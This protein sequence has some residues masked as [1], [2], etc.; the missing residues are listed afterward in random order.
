MKIFL[1]LIVFGLLGCEVHAQSQTSRL[2]NAA[3]TI[4]RNISA[5]SFTWPQAAIT[6][7]TFSVEANN[8]HLNFQLAES[9]THPFSDALGKGQEARQVW[10]VNGLRYEREVR[11]YDNSSVITLS[12]RFI[13]ESTSDIRLGTTQLLQLGENGTWHLGIP[14]SGMTEAPAAVLN[15]GKLAQTA[16]LPFA[17]TLSERDYTSVGV[18][19]FASRVPRAALL[20]GYIRADEASPDI[21][22]NYVR[23]AGGVKLALTSRF[24]NRVIAPKQ[25]V[26]LNRVYL[27][28][29]EDVYALL[30]AY[31]DAMA[32]SAALP[33]R[34]GPVGLW[35][36]WYAHRMEVS[37]ENVL[38]NAAV[39]AQHFAPLGFEYMQVDHGWQRGDITG[40]WVPNERFPHG[41]KWLSDELKNKYGLKL[42]L[43]ISPTDV[44][45]SSQFYQQHP[46]WMLNGE[47]GK[48][49]VHWRWFW[50]PN[51]NCYQLDM[52]RQDAFDYTAATFKRLADEGVSYFKIDFIGGQNKEIFYPS[53]NQLTRGWPELRR[54]MQ[55][56]RAGAGDAWVRY[57]QG[58]PLLAAGLGDGSYGGDDTADAGQPGMFRVLRDNARILATSYWVSERVHTREV[59]DMSIRMHADIEE[60]RVRAALMTLANASI[61]WSDELQ[62][63]PPSRIRMMQQCMPPGN[64]PMRPVDLLERE[65]PSIWHIR[66]KNAAD[67][68]DVVGLFNF[69]E[70]HSEPRRVRLAELGL[71]EKAEYAVFEFWEEKFI[72]IVKGEVELMLPPATSRILSL[73]R[74][75]GKPQLIGTDM[76]VLQG[77][78]ELNQI[79]WDE[80]Q[81]ALSGTFTRM[82]GLSSKAFYYVPPTYAPKFEFP[83]SPRSARLTHVSGNVWM[84]EIEFKQKDFAWTIPFDQIKAATVKT[85]PPCQ[86]SFLSVI[87]NQKL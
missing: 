83:L 58:P 87:G 8:A 50:K 10:R 44:A 23:G 75:T 49:K 86:S 68:W 56:V 4:E 77:F 5:L 17:G 25:T 70:D 31:G 65:V 36:S 1:C 43:W 6:N 28:A 22:A 12:G 39:A 59:C 34:T 11:L 16:A 14:T 20:I 2:T 19:A 78:H 79:A 26:E 24:M 7:A 27:S 9:R 67:S 80:N 76:H 47:D 51:P 41:I 55:A 13:N 54:A 61:S 85:P 35:C 42:G 82:P 46:D 74:L 32:K 29:G 69:N 53:N 38:A 57:C 21:T 30:N 64:P 66:T 63:L 52:S 15:P 40:D 84:Q 81:I 73:R 48:P 45:D 71:D 3:V 60:A 37:E 33:V 18:I 72:G 62:Y